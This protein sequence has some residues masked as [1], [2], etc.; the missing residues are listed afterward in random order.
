[1]FKGTNS[2]DG[3]K[4]GY[5]LIHQISRL[6]TSGIIATYDIEL[7]RLSENKMLVANYSFNSEIKDQSMIF[8]DELHPGICNDFNVRARMERSGI[9]IIADTSKK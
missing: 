1:M 5:S 3:H 7:A 2:E 4:G 6:N 9:H 8:S